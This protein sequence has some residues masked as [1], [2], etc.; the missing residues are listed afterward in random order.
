MDV[1]YDRDFLSKNH[2]SNDRYLKLRKELYN[3]L[4]PKVDLSKEVFSQIKKHRKNGRLLDI[5][6][7]NGDWLIKL[8]QEF[9]YLGHLLGID[10]TKSIMESGID[11]SN[12]QGLRI[13]FDT[14]EATQLAFSD[15]FFDIVTCKHALPYFLDH[16]RAISEAHRCLSD[17]GKY[18]LTLNSQ[19]DKPRR[20]ELLNVLASK[21]GIDNV[22]Q[23]DKHVTAENVLDSLSM[24][25]DIDKKDYNVEIRVTEARPY[26]EALSS[27]RNL[28]FNPIPNEAEWNEV[29]NQ[30]EEMVQQEIGQNGAFID[31]SSFSIIT[32]HK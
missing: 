7:G 11:Y 28:Y 10:L 13:I 16:N 5:G 31:Q 30:I 18:V 6:C 20:E 21:L 8:R 12:T 25:N 2:F 23:H 1:F 15:G 22:H 29:L 4:N 9:K 27:L 24:F 26:I 19:N 3:F 17:K 32:A 14:G